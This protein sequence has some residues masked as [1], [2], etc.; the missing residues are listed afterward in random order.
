MIFYLHEQRNK[1]TRYVREHLFD[2]LSRDFQ[3]VPTVLQARA[4]A[5]HVVESLVTL[6]REKESFISGCAQSSMTPEVNNSSLG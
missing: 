3:L 5:V 2:Q 4:L 6:E 1:V